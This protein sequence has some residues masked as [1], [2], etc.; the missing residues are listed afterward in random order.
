MADETEVL[1]D[2]KYKYTTYEEVYKAFLSS[3]D[4]YDLAAMDDISLEETMYRYL[5][6]GR[7]V[8]ANYAAKDLTDD[9][10]EN[11]RFNVKLSS[12]EIVV[13]AKAMTLEW[14]RV[15]KNSEENMRK[16]IGDRDYNAVQGYQYL[17]KLQALDS[18]LTREIRR[19][20]LR[21][22]YGNS[23]LYGDMK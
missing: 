11:K 8:F 9:D 16:S 15:H 2:D 22:E 6:S 3:V 17:E 12:Y 4:S 5:V 10:P 20:I 23:E 21:L 13:L 7:I 1:Q 18:Q 19:D 14:V